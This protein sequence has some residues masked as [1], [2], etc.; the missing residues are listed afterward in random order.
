MQNFA[1]ETV[2]P[3]AGN[4]GYAASLNEG[5][6]VKASPILKKSDG[7]ASTHSLDGLSQ[8]TVSMWLK[9]NSISSGQVM[10]LVEKSNG[11]VLSRD[12]NLGKEYSIEVYHESSK[13]SADIRLNLGDSDGSKWG[14]TWNSY[15]TVPHDG[16]WNHLTIVWGNRGIDNASP[17]V[18]VVI[19][20]VKKQ[21]NFKGTNKLIK[22]R[23]KTAA[24]YFGV[25]FPP[26][27]KKPKYLNGAIDEI[28][29]WHVARPFEDIVEVR[30]YR[31]LCQDL[32]KG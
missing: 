20:G 25:S 10:G 15:A 23:D 5:L 16:T 7:R 21:F 17:Y 18:A 28:Q 14:Y 24:L 8:L 31:R 2:P 6:Y 1:Q 30:S 26:Y 19:N 29:V 22:N 9:V 32:R 4:G 12:E 3:T 13:G 27:S 11:Q